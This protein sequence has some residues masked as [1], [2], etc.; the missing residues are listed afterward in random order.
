MNANRKIANAL[1][2]VAAISALLIGSHGCTQ[3]SESAHAKTTLSA[4]GTVEGTVQ[5]SQVKMTHASFDGQLAVFEGDGWGF[6]P[7]L[8]LFLFLDEGESPAGRTITVDASN[9]DYDQTRP[10][11][12]YRWRNPSTG[13]IDTKVVMNG[14][15]MQLTFGEVAD[16]TIPGMIEFSV[17][18][19]DTRVEGSFVARIDD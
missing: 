8:L 19:E 12:H 13:E 4:S 3:K 11:V 18:G 17:P 2:A 7:S 1:L 9:E 14:Y 16:G 5:G 10:H 6:N 15:D